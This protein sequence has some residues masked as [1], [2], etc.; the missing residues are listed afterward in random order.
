[1]HLKNN[2]YQLI[3]VGKLF[4]EFLRKTKF[5]PYLKHWQPLSLLNINYNILTKVLAL[6]FKKKRSYL[7][8]ED[9]TGYARGTFITENIKLIEDII[10]Y[11]KNSKLSG[12]LI[13]LEKSI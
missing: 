11:Y 9:Q 4:L 13:D 3:N 5:V 12:L 10:H 1:M 6:R 2:N 7:V 8:H